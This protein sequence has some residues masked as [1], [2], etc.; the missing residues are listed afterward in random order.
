[1]RFNLETHG[2]ILIK[3]H[4]P[5]VVLEYRK[6]ITINQLTGVCDTDL[7]NLSNFPVLISLSGDWLKTRYTLR[8]ST[9]FAEQDPLYRKLKSW[10]F[11]RETYRYR[12]VLDEYR[13]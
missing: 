6:Q 13:P 11:G 10:L 4:H 5:R 7:E 9:G 8:S 3:L 2:A 1:M 12:L